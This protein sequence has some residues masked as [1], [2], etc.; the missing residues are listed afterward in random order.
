[1][2]NQERNPLNAAVSRRQALKLMGGLAGMAT[3][4]ACAAPSGPGAAPA[5]GDSGAAAPAGENPSLLVAHRRE[6]FAEM[7]T[8]FADAVKA[9]G[10]ENNVDIETTTVA[11]E[12]NQDFVPKL[13][14]E[15]QAGNPPN[16]VYHVRLVQLLVANN[17]LEPVTETVDEF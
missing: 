14:A 4:A 1:M 15:V 8:I 13:L 9:W 11:A 2:S 12:A 17:A 10:A 16:L 3:L 5:T 6:Y 7:E